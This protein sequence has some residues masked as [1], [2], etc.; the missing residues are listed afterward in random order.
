MKKR[1]WPILIIYA[2]ALGVCAVLIY[3]VPEVFGL[4]DSTYIA[5]NG[6]ISVSD[7]VR[8]YIFRDE[9]VYVAETD[10]E[11]NRLV[12]EGSLVKGTAKVIE[13][14]GEGKSSVSY[15]YKDELESLGDNITVAS[16]G[17]TDRPGYVYYSIDG[18]EAEF[19]TD[20]IEN[21]T[22][23]VIDD[24]SDYGTVETASNT[25]AGGEPVFKIVN[26]GNWLLLFW[27][28]NENAERYTEGNSIT[29][30]IDGEE[31]PA[32]VKTVISGSELTRVVVQTNKYCTGLMDSRRIDMTVTTA[33]ATGIILKSA[34]IVEKDGVQGVLVRDKVGDNQFKPVKVMAD[35]GEEAAVYS[36]YFM[37]SDMEFVETVK[38]YDEVVT[39]PSDEDV[40]EAVDVND[41]Y[42]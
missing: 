6:D 38:M 10:G 1:R 28:D 12:E 25:C 15:K 27:V 30:T 22:K 33:S 23:S 13:L 37:N 20:N 35:N 7:D 19:S 24:I 2:I 17:T 21:M 32:T 36:D 9:H 11:V 4:F 31:L 39:D 26:N 40:K 5:K 8:A 34:S 14:T 16:N 18:M 29:V 41:K 3:V 42:N